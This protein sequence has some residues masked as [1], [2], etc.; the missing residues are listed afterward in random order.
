MP[1]LQKQV[2]AC[3]TWPAPVMSVWLERPGQSRVVGRLT[4]QSPSFVSQPVHFRGA[5][6]LHCAQHHVSSW[7]TSFNGKG[8][9]RATSASASAIT[10]PTPRSHIHFMAVPPRVSSANRTYQCCSGDEKPRLTGEQLVV[11]LYSPRRER[12]RGVRRD[13]LRTGGSLAAGG[14]VLGGTPSNESGGSPY[15][16]D[17]Q[18]F[19][20]PALPAGNL[21]EALVLTA[22]SK[23]LEEI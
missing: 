19:T 18:A 17:A 1:L 16:P 3:P 2:T 12:S 15:W 7:T 11:C 22:R 4:G 10:T 21:L 14:G 20:Q 5:A 23:T 6:S 9:Q 8:R 13:L